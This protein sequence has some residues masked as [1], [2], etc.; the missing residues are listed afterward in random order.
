MKSSGHGVPFG[1]S[2]R[3]ITVAVP[4]LDYGPPNL[5]NPVLP[6]SPRGVAWGTTSRGPGFEP[7]RAD[8]KPLGPGYICAAATLVTLRRAPGGVAFSNRPSSR[9]AV[10]EGSGYISSDAAKVTLKSPPHGC[11]FATADR[12]LTKTMLSQGPDYISADAKL[13]VLP[14]APRAVAWGTGERKLGQQSPRGSTVHSYMPVEPVK[15]RSV[16]FG[17]APRHTGGFYTTRSGFS[18][19][20]NSPA[21]IRARSGFSSPSNSP[22]TIRSRPASPRRLAAISAP[23]PIT[24]GRSSRLATPPKDAFLTPPKKDAFLPVAAVDL[25]DSAEDASSKVAVDLTDSAKEASSAP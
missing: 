12:D 15:G 4:G 19:P 14:S 10:A 16:G 9:A 7:D 23:S 8:K 24:S 13:A 2:K 18:S 22:A 11:R 1:T 3:L 20:S 6:A 5:K 21:M 17:S 25:I